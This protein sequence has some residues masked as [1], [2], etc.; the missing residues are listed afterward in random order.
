MMRI[1]LSFVPVAVFVGTLVSVAMAISGSSTAAAAYCGTGYFTGNTGCT[2]LSYS[3]DVFSGRTSSSSPDA[4]PDW[5][6][7]SKEGFITYI[8][9]RLGGGA[10]D[11]TGAA[12]VVNQMVGAGTGGGNPAKDRTPSASMMN[13][14]RSRI[15]SS[16]VTME[17]VF[18]DPNG[19]GNGRIS[20]YDQGLNDDFFTNYNPGGR[21][22]ILFKV[23]GVVKYVVEK[24]CGNPVGGFAAGIPD[25]LEFSLGADSWVKHR[26]G[27]NTDQSER[28]VGESFTF[29]H[30]IKNNGP[31][32]MGG[33]FLNAY[34]EW[35]GGYKDGDGRTV[36]CDDSNGLPDGATTGNR[37][38]HSFT[39][40][41][42]A[43][44]GVNYCQRVVASPRAHNNSSAIGSGN[45]CMRV[46]PEWHLANESSVVT[47]PAAGLFGYEAL[48]GDA[49]GFRHRVANDR[50]H[51]MNSTDS[52]GLNGTRVWVE[53][54]YNN[55]GWNEI[56]G[57][58]R[59]MKRAENNI[60][61]IDNA[62][63]L[64]AGF[65]AGD[66]YCQRMRAEHRSGV[67]GSYSGS[68]TS[69]PVCIDG[70]REF[71]LIPSA[72]LTPSAG[73]EAGSNV[74]VQ[75]VVNNE[76]PSMSRDETDWL[77][78][79]FVVPSGLPVPGT[80]TG[81]GAPCAHYANGCLTMVQGIGGF[82][83]GNP[84]TFTR[85]SGATYAAL[86]FTVPDT[87][88]VGTKYCFALSVRPNDHTTTD[89]WRYGTP[90]CVVVGVKPHVAVWGHDLKVGGVID[91]GTSR[92]SGR[93][94]GSWGEYGVL[95][96]GINNAM[97]SAGGFVNGDPSAAQDDWSL[98]TFANT[99]TGGPSPFGFYN[100]VNAFTVNQ[101]GALI[102][103][104]DTSMPSGSYASPFG[105]GYKR[106]VRINGTLRITDNLEYQ[107][108]PYTSIGSIPRVVLI[109]DGVIIDADV[110]RIDPWLVANRI[111]TCSAANDAGNYFPLPS[112]VSLSTTMCQ[113]SLRF[114][115]PV[116][117][118]QLYP[119]RTTNTAD[120]SDVAAEIFNLR[121]DVFLSSY[122]GGGIDNP[123][124]STDLVT[125]VPPRF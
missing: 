57:T 9:N 36:N 112:Q 24:P 18:A 74:R 67:G 25:I 87:A 26:N 16:K 120:D 72:S 90:S 49:Y 35:F 98:L 17:R 31:D 70:R 44:A 92:I 100:G 41:T 111:A 48:G 34:S 116:V 80:A 1:H 95:S 33:R 27:N 3:D 114:N 45:A 113:N 89:R 123:V 97:A 104:G 101:S 39:I 62:G 79:R 23:N 50:Y 99:A 83:A 119:Y 107:N 32:G 14:W 66:R 81:T 64:R 77:L 60:E 13:E 55:E 121:A 4:V 54:R 52:Y 96:N 68:V 59:I 109:A 8:E 11:R 86:N 125:D 12:L 105:A 102:I 61:Q 42:S 91:T 20:F 22:L 21:R 118:N 30:Q 108:G 69:T 51:H 94:Y 19:F 40:P 88:T 115:S 28:R 122:A 65:A 76:G 46:T 38:D 53:G 71:N 78:A 73:A 93:T 82:A 56:A 84:S 110:T 15:R 2:D 43:P 124:A 106:V 85:V 103:N 7:N 47:A 10:R 6:A 75:P 58:S 29:N 5:A 37:C 63:T 117:A